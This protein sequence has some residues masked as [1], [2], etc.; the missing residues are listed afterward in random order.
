LRE[1]PIQLG[2]TAPAQI[3]HGGA[4]F[5]LGLQLEIPIPWRLQVRHA[6]SRFSVQ[7]WAW[8]VTWAAPLLSL[9][10]GIFRRVAVPEGKLSGPFESWNAV[11]VEA[12]TRAVQKASGQR[13][14][15]T[16]Q[17]TIR[18]SHYSG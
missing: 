2:L 12:C 16:Y 18:R 7:A 1:D 4:F 3:I 9:V 10:P 11:H 13:P 8:W 15:L 17:E 5:E 6:A 14:A